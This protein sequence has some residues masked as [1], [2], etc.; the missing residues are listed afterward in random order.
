MGAAAWFL[1]K[2][3]DAQSLMDSEIG[4]GSPNDASTD[5]VDVIAWCNP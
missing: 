5:D 3:G 4:H 2:E 1:P